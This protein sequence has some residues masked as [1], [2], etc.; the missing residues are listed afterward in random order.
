MMKHFPILKSAI[1]T[2]YCLLASLVIGCGESDPRPPVEISG[3]VNLDGAP[4]QEGSIHFTSGQTGE[5]SYANLNEKGQY[6]LKFP[7][8][9]LNTQYEIKI[10]PPVV[11]EQDAHALEN[12]PPSKMKQSIPKKYLN[13]TT[14]GLKVKIEKDGKNEFDFDLTSK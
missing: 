4:L 3:V 1:V 6:S 11:D 8:A 13:R 12:N 7:K 9:D 10:G 2:V 14:S 5:T